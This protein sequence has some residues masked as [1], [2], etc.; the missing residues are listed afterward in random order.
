MFISLTNLNLVLFSIYIA[1]WWICMGWIVIVRILSF[2]VFIF[3]NLETPL[4]MLGTL[5]SP[6]SPKNLPKIWLVSPHVPHVCFFAP[7]SRI[8]GGALIWSLLLSLRETLLGCISKMPGNLTILV[9]VHSMMGNVGSRWISNSLD[10]IL[11][12][13]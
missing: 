11:N 9:M 5:T 8:L 13:V 10:C 12:T 1:Q 2:L 6:L 3:I 7:A 4:P